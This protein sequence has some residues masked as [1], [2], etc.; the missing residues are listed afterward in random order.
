MHTPQGMLSL[1]W[2]RALAVVL[3]AMQP[4]LAPPACAAK[5]AAQLR[6][7][8]YVV[9]DDL[10]P[11]LPIYGQA[12][13]HAPNTQ[14]L[15]ARGV[16]FDAAF[17]QQAVC[18]PSR[19][20]FMSGRR[21]DLTQSWN[22]EFDFRRTPSGADWHTLPGWFLASG[23]LTLG[24]GKLF[25]EGLPANGDGTKSWTDVPIQFDC[26][27]SGAKGAGTYCDPDM[28]PCSTP[29]TADAPYPRWCVVNAT[30]DGRGH[31]AYFEDVATVD[32]ALAKLRYAVA[33][34]KPFFLGVSN[35]ALASMAASHPLCASAPAARRGRLRAQTWRAR[36][37]PRVQVG[38]RKP[39]LDFRFP[40]PYLDRYP[41][42]GDI[43]LPARR[44]PPATMPQVAYHDTSRS[45]AEERLWAGWGFVD[46]WTPMRNGTVREMR[47]HYYG[48]VSFMDNL[49][50]QL[51]DGLD[52][53]GAAGNTVVCFHSDH[54]W[55]LGENNM[56]RK[57]G[58]TELTTRVP[59]VIAVPWL[60][61]THGQRTSAFFELVDVFPTLVELA[62]LPAPYLSRPVRQAPSGGR[63]DFVCLSSA[64]AMHPPRGPSA[65][66]D[67]P[68]EG[69]QTTH[70]L[71]ILLLQ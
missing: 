31:G 56:F 27:D 22:F 38:L 54:G 26:K 50:G 51:L 10:R 6:N 23:Y 24:T 65:R 5:P 39:H 69:K 35:L 48:A 20:S 37:S 2:V 13:I 30:E 25:H 4:H 29:G 71:L 44:T 14:R 57:F 58:D 34:S 3:A 70:A 9:V 42:V 15:A 67:K 66:A 49:L 21:P 28:V 8:L 61:A 45:P 12:L 60:Q 53:S 43:E 33:S 36:V 63:F 19:N 1:G 62:G 16:V 17:C 40:A 59:L 52:A 46:P 47:L 7:V 41:A 32:D 64:R 55:A 18:S 68:D 11:E